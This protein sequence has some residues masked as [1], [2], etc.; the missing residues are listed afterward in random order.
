MEITDKTRKE[1]IYYVL[2]RTPI[3][4]F[5]GY[6]NTFSTQVLYNGHVIKSELIKKYKL[7]GNLEYSIFMCEIF[8]KYELSYTIKD[9]RLKID[10]ERRIIKYMRPSIEKGNRIDEFNKMVKEYNV[11]LIPQKEITKIY[12]SILKKQNNKTIK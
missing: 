8:R 5:N 1:V 7:S 12:K 9:T 4:R 10:Q 11:S 3:Y 6:I 2:S